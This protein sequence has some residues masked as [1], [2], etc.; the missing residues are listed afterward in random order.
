[1]ELKLPRPC[2][3]C[4]VAITEQDFR[5]ERPGPIF[6]VGRQTTA[7]HARHFFGDDG[8]TGLDYERNL[9]LLA[10]TH[11]KSEGWLVPS[12]TPEE[13]APT[14]LG[15]GS[16]LEE[17]LRET[18]TI[19][20]ACDAQEFITVNH[21]TDVYAAIIQLGWE[22]IPTQHGST[23]TGKCPQCLTSLGLYRRGGH[24]DGQ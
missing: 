10:L 15:V 20:C 8:R 11:G 9:T 24:A 2:A 22:L 12:F 1:M 5:A 3:I 14:T 23:L 18:Y 21:F 7:A 17:P 16:L 13:L 19:V 4:G 6:L